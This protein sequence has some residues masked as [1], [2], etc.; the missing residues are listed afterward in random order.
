M[1]I[2]VG[3]V[4]NADV[5]VNLA[6]LKPLDKIK[7]AAINAYHNTGIYKR[8]FAESEEQK[9]AQRR[10]VREAFID[11]LLAAIQPELL[12]N[13]LL[14]R[15]DDQCVGILV[16]VPARFVQFVD[17]VITAHEFDAYDI[18]PIRASKLLVKVADPP[19]L[20]YITHKGG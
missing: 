6:D 12:N 14:S 11:D 1:R 13:S 8:R 17:E 15:K 16:E 7:A 2:Q 20:L 5:E 18:V 9:E 19:C 4:V 10:K 3:R